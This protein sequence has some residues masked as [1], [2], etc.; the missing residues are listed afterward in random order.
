MFTLEKGKP[1][2]Y[3]IP[4]S[5]IQEMERQLARL[6]IPMHGY[7]LLQGKAVVAEKYYAPYDG[8]SLH[9]MYSVTKSFTALA[10]GLLAGQGRI[11]LEDKICGYFPEY[12]SPKDTHP[13]CLELTIED[14]LTMRTC[15][16]S[17]TYKRYD[18]PD[19]TQSFFKVRPD[20]VPGTVFSYD[21][22]STHVL[23]A[24]VEKLTRMPA[25][26]YLRKGV[27]D[28]LGF[29]KEAYIITDPAGVSQGGSGLMCT[30]RDMAGAAYLCSHYGNLDGEQLLPLDFMQRA[31]TIQV[32]TDL[33][34]K[35][36]EQYGY[37]YFFWMPREEGFCM[38]GMG[39]QLA[40][41]FPKLDFCLLTMADTNGIPAGLQ[42]IYDCFYRT[43]YP[44]LKEREGENPLAYA[45]A[46]LSAGRKADWKRGEAL[47]R[48]RTEGQVYEFY[49]NDMRLL[50]ISFHWR[51]GRMEIANE[52]GTYSFVFGE[53]AGD[54]DSGTGSEEWKLQRFLDTG[55]R[56]GCRGYWSCGHF[57]LKC[58]LLDEEMGHVNLE[59][60]WKEERVSV[61]LE[62]TGESFFDRWKGFASAV[63][64]T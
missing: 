49:G 53:D 21:T 44:C 34:P 51:E 55:Y 40:L 64:R 52:E 41:C 32:N 15:H 33:N 58:Y 61:H 63:R 56:C 36:D 9:R 37:G 43:V 22:S 26:D 57:V 29:S 16:S 39:G 20:H 1:E 42:I 5:R 8:D 6:G 50:W 46:S 3:G 60:A 31:L 12:A 54:K 19:W 35:L 18:G 23:T 28:R 7:L 11:R 48:E 25:L 59:A 47:T 62:S 30:L 27:L 45:A 24:L 13:W 4:S 10:I 17:T 2:E 38:F 14:M